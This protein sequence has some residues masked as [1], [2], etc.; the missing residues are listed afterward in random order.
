[1]PDLLAVVSRRGGFVVPAVFP[2]GGKWGTSMR[3]IQL[4]AALALSAPAGA[5]QTREGPLLRGYLRFAGIGWHIKD[6]G[7]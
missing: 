3:S 6:R 4:I 7:A 1:M 2:G 5:I